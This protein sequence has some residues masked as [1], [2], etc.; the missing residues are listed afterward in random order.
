MLL[1]IR[2]AVA[3]AT[4]AGFFVVGVALPVFFL[5]SA[6]AYATVGRWTTT[7]GRLLGL[8]ATLWVTGPSL[9]SAW[10]RT[11][12]PAEGP[13]VGRSE[14]SRRL[15][16]VSAALGV[17]RLDEVRVVPGT[18]IVARFD[19]GLLGVRAGPPRLYVG[20]AALL[21]LGEDELI[22]AITR[23]LARHAGRLPAVV[24]RCADAAEV[25]GER[26]RGFPYALFLQA[27]RWLFRRLVRGVVAAQERLANEATVRL[28]G[29]PVVESA[30]RRRVLGEELWRRFAAQYPGRGP[31]SGFRYLLTEA[32]YDSPALALLEKPELLLSELGKDVPAVSWPDA[33]AARAETDAAE[34]AEILERTELVDELTVHAL[35]ELL[36]ADALT[37]LWES[38]T[39]RPL[40]PAVQAMLTSAAAS[41]GRYPN[42]LPPEP[43]ISRALDDPD[44]VAALRSRLAELGVPL[45]YRPDPV[46]RSAE[47]PKLVLGTVKVDAKR[48]DLAVFSWGLVVLPQR[49]RW[50]PGWMVDSWLEQRRIERLRALPCHELLSEPAARPVAATAVTEVRFPRLPIPGLRSTLRLADGS[51]VRIRLRLDGAAEGF[52]A[53]VTLFMPTAAAQDE[54]P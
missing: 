49:W 20:V 6:V 24:V 37:E 8:A 47:R 17:H 36:A 38:L 13:L 27:W 45:D 44:E 42:G 54:A 52:E 23:E 34:M 25:A 28:A 18:H 39:S 48:A 7:G 35:L 12:A 2:T 9:W 30:A 51:T 29:L 31:V 21:V 3:L 53:L 14:L 40:S 1:R 11:P 50:R 5:A 43:L 26:L 4:V 16:G 22:A 19:G 41:T 32:G 15:D 10:H 33:V 46:S